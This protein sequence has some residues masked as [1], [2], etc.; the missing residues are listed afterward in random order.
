[1][2][3]TKSP[4]NSVG[5]RVVESGWARKIRG[6]FT[7]PLWS[8]ASCSLC[9]PVG[10]RA[11]TPSTG[12]PSRPSLPHIIRPRP[13]GPS[14]LLSRFQAE[15][16]AHWRVFMAARVALAPHRMLTHIFLRLLATSVEE[17]A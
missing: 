9:S 11:Y 15:L 2:N 1:M 5:A 12:R 17:R 13:Y 16:D 6:I 14:G 10:E 7:R 4:S 3:L 8:P